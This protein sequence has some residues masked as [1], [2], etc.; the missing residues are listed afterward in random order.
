MSSLILRTAV[1]L[2]MP[3]ALLFSLFMAIKGHNEPGGGFIGG[4]I[5]A[6]SLAIYRMSNGPDTFRQLIPLHPRIIVFTGMAIA[7]L[8]ALAP[9]ALG[10]PLLHTWHGY[11]GL[12]GG[13]TAHASSALIFDAGVFL[14]VVGASIGMIIRLSEELEA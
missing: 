12:P 11:V 7:L 10:L 9:L 5:A 4:L 14:V 13:G 3:L 8:T 2:I 1:A 6:V